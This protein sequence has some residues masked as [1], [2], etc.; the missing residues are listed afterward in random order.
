MKETF[1]S[2]LRQ[3]NFS[4]DKLYTQVR[5]NYTDCVLFFVEINKIFPSNRYFGSIKIKDILNTFKEKY[6]IK[7]ENIITGE[8]HERKDEKSN[9]ILNSFVFIIDDDLMVNCF[10]DGNE[11]MYSFRLYY[12]HTT[13]KKKLDELSDFIKDHY[14]ESKNSEIGIIGNGQN[15]LF[16]RFFRVN[17]PDISI[18]G[19][20]NDDFIN[21]HERILNKLN[22]NTFSK[23]VVLFHGKPGTGKTTY[24]RYISSLIN[25]RMIFIPQEL[26]FQIA[27]PN[28]L[29]LLMDYPNSI[30]ILEDAENVIKDR[31]GDQNSPVANILNISDG[32]LSDCLNLQL[33]CTFNTDIGKIDQALLRKGRIISK[34]E[35]KELG[36]EKA[37]KLAKLKGIK[38]KF[39]KN[40]TLA[41]IFNSDDEDYLKDTKSPV[42]FKLPSDPKGLKESMQGIDI[43]SGEEITYF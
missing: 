5:S 15:G 29:S 25:K 34:Y 13:D 22:G 2:V 36:M 23:G 4:T 16:I 7:K 31:M 9:F 10:S 20:Y 24:I 27:S 12:C 3:E 43:P 32:L 26:A 14:E 21:V 28:F 35:F 11:D 33:I 1:D 30:L 39:D 17:V 18:S 41:E 6:K 42:G 8:Y 38:N 19:Y 40:V 37:N